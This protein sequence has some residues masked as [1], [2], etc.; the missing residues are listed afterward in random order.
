MKRLTLFCLILSMN[1]FASTENCRQPQDQYES[2][3]CASKEAETQLKS[4]TKKITDFCRQ[5]PEVLSETGGS[6]HPEMLYKCI[7][8][9]AKN[10]SKTITINKKD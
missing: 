4:L 3:I 9:K 6:L 2:N 5:E 1:A 8:R 7:T 10:L